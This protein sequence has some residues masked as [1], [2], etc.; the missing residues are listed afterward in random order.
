MKTPFEIVRETPELLVVNKPSGLLTMPARGELAKEKHLVGLLHQTYGRVYITH[1]LDRDASGLIIFARTPEAHR[2][3][4]GLFETR[5]VEKRYVVVVEGKVAENRG[6]IDKP[7]KQRGSGRVSVVFDGK[8]SLTKY[9]VMERLR[10]A[11]ILEV[12]IVTGRRHQIRAHMYSIG[13]P[14]LGDSLYGD[15]V[16]QSKFPRLMLHSWRLRLK[17]M[18]GKSMSFEVN[19]PADFMGVLKVLS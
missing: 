18:S 4:S 7:L 6:E 9:T 17:D 1:R 19:P 16:R 2:Y 11:T 14:V 12:S 8:P 15:A 13:H 3:Y 10:S 5:E